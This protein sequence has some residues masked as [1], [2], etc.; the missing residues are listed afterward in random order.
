MLLALA[1][2][3]GAAEGSSATS[4]GTDAGSAQQGETDGAPPEPEPDADAADATTADGGATAPLR[5]EGS[6]FGHFPITVDVSPEAPEAVTAAWVGGIRTYALQPRDDGRLEMIVQGHPEAGPH[7]VRIMT[8][9]GERDLLA[10]VTYRQPEHPAFRR[11]VGIGASLTQG[12]QRGVPSFHGGLMSPPAQ[13]ARRAGAYL[14]MPLLKPGLIEPLEPSDI[15]APPAC[16]GPDIVDYLVAQAQALLPTLT[17]DAGHFD[18]GVARIDP[19][20]EVWNVAVG[21]S[22]VQDLLE[23]PPISAIVVHLLGHL[24]YDPTG[25]ALD[26]ITETQLDRVD[27]LQPT[28]VVS[29]DLFGNNV[30]GAIV[31]GDEIRPGRIT[32]AEA[33]HPAIVGVVERLAAVEAHSFLATLPRPSLLPVTRQKRADM[34][35]SGTASEDVDALVAEIDARAEAA[36]A[37]MAEAAA[38]FE[39]VHVVDLSARID[40]LLEVGVDANGDTLRPIKFGGLIGIDGTHFTD[41]GYAM[42]ADELGRAINEVLGTDLPPIDLARVAAGD[43]ETPSALTAAGLDVAA[44]DR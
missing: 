20:L 32:A 9:E 12:V 30:I 10:E 40:A 15:G 3:D 27:A 11:I 13:L 5:Y 35:A 18:W 7:T 14:A 4:G 16:R 19:D 29:T 33:L 42:L 23:L 17:N 21:N 31:S 43:V 44:C 36:N 1:C 26:P 41:T 6:A 38:R 2:D 34:I 28:L 8:A 22:Q 37:V 24:V 25:G 39:N